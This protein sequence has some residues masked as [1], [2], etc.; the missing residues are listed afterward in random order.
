M[1]GIAGFWAARSASVET[2]ERAASQMADT[3][4]HRGPDGEGVWVDAEAGVGLGHRRLSIVDLSDAARQPMVSITGRYVITYNG[5]IYNF[6]EIARE[7][8]ALGSR[9]NANSDTAVLLAAVERW[10]LVP[11]VRRC[12]GMFAFA[13]WD[14]KERTLALVRDRLGIK[15]L[16]VH[17]SGDALL[18]GS[19]LKAL[20]RH[21]A[22]RPFLDEN[23]IQAYLRYRY[24]PAPGTIYRNTIKLKAG[25]ILTIE[26]PGKVLPEAVSFWS[27]ID[28]ARSGGME[29]FRGGD[30]EA[31]NALDRLLDDAVGQHMVS[32]VPI[33]AFLSGGIDSSVVV[34]MMRSHTRQPVKTFC[35]GFRDARYDEAKDA[36]AVAR[37]LGTDHTELYVSDGDVRAV[38]PELP[39]MFDEPFAD[40]SQ[41]PTYLVSALA[42]QHVTVSLS[43]DGGDEL[44]GG[45]TR[46][47][48]VPRAWRRLGVLPSGVRATALGALR[49]FSPDT[50][51]SI[52]DPLQSLLPRRLRQRQVGD[53][54]HK[55]AL[56]SRAASLDDLFR[57]VT[58][59]HQ[60]PAGLTRQKSHEP[61]HLLAL[62]RELPP[63]DAASRMMLADTLTYLPDDILTKVDRCSMAVGLESRVPLLDHRLVEFAWQLPMH[64]KIREGRSKWILRQVLGRYVPP[65]LFERP[66]TGFDLPIAQWLRGPLREWAIDTLAPES[67]RRAGLF[68]PP[69]VRR[70]LDA[71]LSGRSNNRDILWALLM[72]ETWRKHWTSAVV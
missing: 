65:A 63:L 39:Y 28:V 66:K 1:C 70:L 8:I 61:D 43:G 57:S 69:Q 21:P 29:P 5:E 27:A 10:G 59:T 6:R 25:H 42:R 58:S 14:R 37:H 68:D 52:V 45:Y 64:M 46:Y 4:A 36:A 40:P 23:A 2:L 32:D 15:P 24:V 13:I 56:N 17:Q 35:L 67:L 22:F 48:W 11:A 26:R 16:Y 18:F 60:D 3:L 33:G 41:V 20:R 7:L 49:M 9:P 55:L 72:F 31:E 19:E 50:I 53:K 44:F 71:H 34:A 62:L 12:N 51:S 38:V 47:Q 54:L 30:R